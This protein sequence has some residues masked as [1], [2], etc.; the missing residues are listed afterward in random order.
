MQRIIATGGEFFVDVDQVLYVADLGAENNFVAREA[1]TF[2]SFGGAQRTFS[3]GAAG[4]FH[5]VERFGKKVVVV[6][7][8]G[9]KDGIKRA[10]VDADAD[11]FVVFDG[12]FNHDAEIV[13]LFAADVDVAGIDAV[14]GERAGAGGIFFQQQ[15]AVVME[16]ADDGDIDAEGAQGVDNDWNGLSSLVGVNCDADEFR[17]GT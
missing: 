2:G 14:F 4:D 6:H 3:N 9:E 16:V 8:L 17:T 12:R 13:I 11:G 7:H 15:M 5:G 10:P 1:V